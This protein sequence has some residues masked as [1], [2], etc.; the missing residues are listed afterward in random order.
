MNVPAPAPQTSTLAII[1]L[2][3]GIVCWF[4]LPFIG[5][6]VAIICGH[7]ARSEIRNAAPG[8]LEGSGMALAGLILGWVQI[9]LIALAIVFV[10]LFLGG[11]AFLA[12]GA[13]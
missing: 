1:S 4:V 9:A 3:F 10:F 7:L 8:T 11:L 2:I 13:H 12:A 6:L 5:A